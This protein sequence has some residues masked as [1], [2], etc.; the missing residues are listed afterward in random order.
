VFLS[1]V[2]DDDE[3]VDTLERGADDFVSKPFNMS[4]LLA[5]VRAM[6]RLAERR[7]DALSGPWGPRAPC[8]C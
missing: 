4:R 1:G 6:L 2:E 7:H 8:R 5:K 3:I